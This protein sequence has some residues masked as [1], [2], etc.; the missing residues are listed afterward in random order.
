MQEFFFCYKY[1][2]NVKHLKI[3]VSKPLYFGLNVKSEQLYYIQ[4]E[5]GSFC[6]CSVVKDWKEQFFV[7]WLRK[8]VYTVRA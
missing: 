3:R 7:A 5:C 8:H 4:F 1:K 6:L 2:Y